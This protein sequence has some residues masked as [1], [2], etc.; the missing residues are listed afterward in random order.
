M[1]PIQF[2]PRAIHE[3][4]GDGDVATIV[5]FASRRGII[6]AHCH[7]LIEFGTDETAHVGRRNLSAHVQCHKQ[8]GK[9]F[10]I[11]FG[12]GN[13]NEFVKKCRDV[14]VFCAI[15]ILIS[16]YCLPIKQNYLYYRKILYQIWNNFSLNFDIKLN[17]YETVLRYDF[18]NIIKLKACLNKA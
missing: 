1:S 11:F 12:G 10:S 2:H 16:T 13:V 8:E 4:A 15:F 7:R 18:N 3:W 14:C 17:L 5:S 9:G 6:N